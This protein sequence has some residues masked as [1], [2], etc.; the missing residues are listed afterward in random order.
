MKMP[1]SSTSS[2]P[3]SIRSAVDLPDPEGPTSTSSSPSPSVRSSAST[4]GRLAP[5]K[6]RVARSKRTSAIAVL[7]PIE[8]RSGESAVCV[9]EFAPKPVLRL[10]RSTKVVERQECGA[11]D[12]GRIGDDHMRGRSNLGQALPYRLD[13]QGRAATDDPAAE[14]DFE[15]LATDP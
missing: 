11:G 7:H 4:A 8:P 14:H 1:P 5:E 13:E 10:Q 12:W 15:L 9:D 6:M 3:A 2:S